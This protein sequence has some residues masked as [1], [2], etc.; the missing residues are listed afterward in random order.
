MFGTKIELC[1]KLQEDI[2]DG[3]F[4]REHRYTSLLFI[5]ETICNKVNSFEEENNGEIK[6]LSKVILFEISRS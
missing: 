6:N 4:E 1:C 3:S 2:Q 5:D